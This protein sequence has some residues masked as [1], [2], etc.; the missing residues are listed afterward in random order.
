VSKPI[1]IVFFVV[2]VIFRMK[3]KMNLAPKNMTKYRVPKNV[4]SKKVGSKNLGPKKLGP[5]IFGCKKFGQKSKIKMI[6]G[7]EKKN[8][9]CS[10]DKC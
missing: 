6:L 7:E 10:Q 3:L 5:K 4:V 8:D 9:N 2:F 1:R